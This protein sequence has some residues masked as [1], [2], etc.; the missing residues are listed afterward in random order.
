MSPTRSGARRRDGA[1]KS[2]AG[3]RRQSILPSIASTGRWVSIL[4]G[5]C[6]RCRSGKIF[7]GA[8]AIHEKCPSCRL[9][10]SREPGYFTGAMYISYA[11]AFPVLGGMAW[12]IHLAMPE[13]TFLAVTI[14]ATA[15]CL[16]GTPFVFRY[17]RIIWI[18]FDR[19][20]D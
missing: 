20:V 3:D 19:W 12:L 15:A 1:M 17:S 9:V 7:R 14:L 6:P 11:M 5:L 2:G 16:P 13:L 18:H 4:R 10:F 8:I